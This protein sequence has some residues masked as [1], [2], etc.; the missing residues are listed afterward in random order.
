MKIAALYDVHGN[1]PALKAVLDDVRRAG[2]DEVVIG[3][4]VVPGPMPVECLDA[5]HDLS[6]PQHFIYGNGETDIVALGRGEELTRVPEHFHDV[7]RWVVDA[8]EP[9]HLEE[10]ASWPLSVRLE[11]PDL[12]VVHFCHATPRDDNEIF[13]RLTPEEK[14]RPILEP[15]EA[16][17]VVCGHTHMAFDRHVGHVRVVN[18][19]S[20]GMPFGDP[21]AFWCLIS[22]QGILIRRTMYDLEAAAARLDET[23]YPSSDYDLRRPLSEDDM[24]RIFEAAA[25]K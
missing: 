6:I 2:V 17:I 18:A 25:L 19:G 5:L 7:M 15:V 14:L 11:V 23:G 8:L 13:T 4:D 22:D 21:G 10:F 3:G 9:H 20:V 16:D 12:G 24:L 1:L